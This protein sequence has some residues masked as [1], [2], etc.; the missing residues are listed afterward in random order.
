MGD[1]AN[2][3]DFCCGRVRTST[4]QYALTWSESF[5]PSRQTG[6]RKTR[7]SICTRRATRLILR[8]SCATEVGPCTI[9][10]RS[11]GGFVNGCCTTTY[12]DP[13]TAAKGLPRDRQT[14]PTQCPTRRSI[15]LTPTLRK[16]QSSH[17]F[18]MQGARQNTSRNQSTRTPLSL[19]SRYPS[20]KGVLA[21]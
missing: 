10:T 14:V 16:S 6:R 15:L 20:R 13:W 11:L 12:P 5:V 4:S 2:L 7:P 21:R 1:P 9:R 18:S 8:Q 17:P 19:A 3:R